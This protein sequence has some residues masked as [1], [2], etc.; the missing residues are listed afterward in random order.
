MVWVLSERIWKGMSVKGGQIVDLTP[1][2]R[3]LVR[4]ACLQCNNGELEFDA[5]ARWEHYDNTM[6]DG[7]LQLFPKA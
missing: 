5:K 4:F 1:I 7:F 2:Q 3:M 6:M